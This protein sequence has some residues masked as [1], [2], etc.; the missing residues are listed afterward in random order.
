MTDKQPFAIEKQSFTTDPCEDPKYDQHVAY[1]K[2]TD[3]YEIGDDCGE[4]VLNLREIEKLL[5]LVKKTHP[6][7]FMDLVR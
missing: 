6:E 7:L 1:D 3:S 2:T 4:C 5:K